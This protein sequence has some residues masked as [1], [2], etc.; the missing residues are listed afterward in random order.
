MDEMS[1][2]PIDPK[3]AQLMPLS[4]YAMLMGSIFVQRV[5]G[6]FC[7]FGALLL[8][9]R[10]NIEMGGRGGLKSNSKTVWT[11]CPSTVP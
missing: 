7:P 11:L 1:K 4:P 5:F 10:L 3:A 6:Y 9:S 8:E 2:H